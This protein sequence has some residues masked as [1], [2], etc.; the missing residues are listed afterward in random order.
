MRDIL[1]CTKQFLKWLP[2]QLNGDATKFNEAVFLTE[3]R[4]E[5]AGSVFLGARA[6]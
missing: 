3:G 2:A 1:R 4:A 5:Q 6:K